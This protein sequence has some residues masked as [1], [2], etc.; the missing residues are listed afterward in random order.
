MIGS[1]V[2]NEL[3]KNME[4]RKEAWPNLR[5]S[6]G[7]RIDEMIRPT[8]TSQGAGSIYDSMLKAQV[9]KLRSRNINHSATTSVY[10]RLRILL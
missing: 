6:S 9:S 4:G 7:F 3:G 1:L 2:N 8:K 10:Q 5:K